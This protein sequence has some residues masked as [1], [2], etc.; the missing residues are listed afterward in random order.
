MPIVYCE[1][2]FVELK[3]V[4]MCHC[5]EF[6]T[7]T[8]E[9]AMY[10]PEPSTLVVL[11]VTIC[12]IIGLLLLVIVIVAVQRQMKRRVPV[13]FCSDPPPFLPSV[14]AQPMRREHDR[15]ALIAFPDVDSSAILPTYE[16]ALRTRPPGQRI[17]R[18]GNELAHSSSIRSIRS[19]YRPLPHVGV[20]SISRV[21]TPA[22]QMREQ[23]TSQEQRADHRR[24]SIV[25]NS[26]MM[27]RDNMSLAFGSVETVNVSDATSTTVTIGTF[28]SGGSNPSLATSVSQR[29]TAGSVAS[30]SSPTDEG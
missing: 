18:F 19:D 30:A 11:V 12:G 28:E 9:S 24:N 21:G 25:T 6:S 10:V 22:V 14:A 27:T 15:V 20:S 5:V 1:V 7:T 17:A 29:A 16:E 3:C 2:Y 13:P 26:S 8:V 4:L 23:H